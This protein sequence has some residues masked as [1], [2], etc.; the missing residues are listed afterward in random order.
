MVFPHVP[1]PTANTTG[2]E[3]LL[4]E[5]DLDE[6]DLGVFAHGV[7]LRAR[8]RRIFSAAVIS[9]PDNSKRGGSRRKKK[10]RPPLKRHD[11]SC[12]KVFHNIFHNFQQHSSEKS[13]ELCAKSACSFF[14]HH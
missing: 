5:A 9:P 7:L 6:G 14:H 11:S 2:V 12:G 8:Y 13:F 10:L 4:C 1:A 3:D